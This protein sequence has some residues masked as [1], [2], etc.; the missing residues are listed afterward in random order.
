MWF[1]TGN[2]ARSERLRGAIQALGWDPLQAETLARE[3]LAAEPDDRHAPVILGAA[4]RLQHRLED[5]LAVLRS[6]SAT[7]ANAWMVHAELGQTLFALGRSREAVGPLERA[8]SLNRDWAPGW[9]ILG[10]IFR[11]AGDVA[12]AEA[13]DDHFLCAQLRDHFLREQAAALAE[14]RADQARRALAH[15][16]R[17]PSAALLL[18]EAL[19]RLE[20][21]AEA[22]RLLATLL[23]D[24]P[25]FDLGRLSHAKVLK[26]MRRFPQAL[27]EVDL[28][29]AR[30]PA[31][32]RTRTLKSALLVEL[33]DFAGACEITR[34]LLVDVPDQPH[35]WTAYGF[36]L[37][38]LGR[39]DDA[40]EAFRRCLELTNGAEAAPPR[41]PPPPSPRERP[42]RAWPSAHPA[43]ASGS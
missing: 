22:E 9:R 8:A 12:G 33:G 35:A 29:L 7:G 15:N 6:A 23:R 40:A 19:R 1:S 28:L 43:E 20:R 21:L 32:I 42:R 30:N 36:A 5:A 16:A 26:Q 34:G 10:D 39:S 27:R 17:S 24:A 2:G 3:M 25:A 4:L 13:A 41:A 37:Q 18:A 31:D 14:G 11:L 38:A